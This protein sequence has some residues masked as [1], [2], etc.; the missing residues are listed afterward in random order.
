MVSDYSGGSFLDCH[1][2][3][4]CSTVK[5][6]MLISDDNV[7]QISFI[8]EQESSQNLSRHNE[9]PFIMQNYMFQPISGHPQVRSF[10]LKFTGEGM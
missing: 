4:V 3:K 2:V 6:Q 1:T 5:T 10:C 8:S 9:I 7:L